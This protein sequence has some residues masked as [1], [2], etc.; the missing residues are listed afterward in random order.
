MEGIDALSYILHLR[1]ILFKEEERQNNMGVTIIRNGNVAGISK[2]AEAIAIITLNEQGFMH[3]PK[4]NI[5]YYF[6]PNMPLVNLSKEELEEKFRDG[7]F[8]YVEKD[9]PRIPGILEEEGIKR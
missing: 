2:I 6:A 3:N 5:Y 8:A 7:T 1:K 9:D 4:Q